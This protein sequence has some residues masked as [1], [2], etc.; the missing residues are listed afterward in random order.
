MCR[1]GKEIGELKAVILAGGKGT[2]LAA[3]TQNIPKPMVKIGGRPIL[4][5]QVRLLKRYGIQDIILITGHLSSVI[6]EYFGDGHRF[7]VNITYFCETT[8]LGTTGGI[9]EIEQ[10]LTDDFLVLYGDVILDMD[11]EK[12]VKFHQDKNSVCTLVLHPNDHPYDSD[13]V[14]IDIDC[15]VK[16]FHPKPH[17]RDTYYHNLVNA[18]VYIMSPVIIRYIEKGVSADFGRDL[19]PSLYGKERFYGYNSSEYIK[20]VGTPDRLESVT[21]D[22]V[23]GKIARLNNENAR[24]AIFLD[25]DGVINKEIGHLH[26]ASDFELLPGVT[27]AVKKINKTEYLAILVTNQPVVARNLCSIEELGD[28]HKKME[29]LLGLEEAKLDGIYICPHHPDKGFPEENP[30]YK[31]CCSCRKPNTGM[32]E[33]AMLDFNITTSGSYIIGDSWRDIEC[34]HNAGLSTIFIRSGTRNESHNF[35]PDYSFDNLL[36]AVNFILEESS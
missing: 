35:E 3:H 25:R 32:I 36:E 27:E 5:H 21:R 19:F 14:E 12:L 23:S 28:I 29:T 8:P 16:A 30:A 24:H 10:S 6:E 15:R 26:R 13:L 22:L 31:I 7:G 18:A 9:K 20:D 17:P 34:G 4:E 11:L 33:S 1:T 2:R